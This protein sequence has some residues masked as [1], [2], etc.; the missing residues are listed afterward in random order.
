[1]GEPA[2]NYLVAK[3]I[4]IKMVP[5][6]LPYSAKP[7]GQNLPWKPT[8]YEE[9]HEPFTYLYIMIHNLR[10]CTCSYRSALSAICFVVKFCIRQCMDHVIKP[11]ITMKEE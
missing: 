8:F 1:M 11:T 5:R 10:T 3:L 6:V 9:T 2:Y 4:R 7:L